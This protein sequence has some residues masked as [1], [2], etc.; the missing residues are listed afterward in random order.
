MTMYLQHFGLREPPFRITPHTE[1]FFSGANRGATLEALL[2]AITAGEGLVK[3]TGEVGSGKTMLC[4]VLME[5]LPETV[6]TLYLAVPSLTRDEMLAAIGDELGI[7][8]TGANTTKLIRLLQ[9]KLIAIH[10]EGRQ[11]VALID[12]AHAM[13][14]ATLEEVRL[15]SNLETG[16]EKLLQ[17]VLFGQPELDEHLALPNMRQLKERITHAFTLAPLPPREIRD[18][19]SFRMRAAG[20]HG[21]DLFDDEVLGIIADASE[22]LTRRINIYSDKALLAAFAA[23]THTVTADHARAAVSDTQI[24]VTRRESPRKMASVAAAG[25]VGGILIGFTAAQFVRAPA[26]APQAVAAS[27]PVKQEQSAPIPAANVAAVAQTVAAVG[28]APPPRAT[29]ALVVP[30]HTFDARLAAGRDLLAG[31]PGLYSV[32]L[33]VA[34]ARQRDYVAGYLAEAAHA[35]SADKLFLVPAGSP[36][37]P[38]LGVLFGAFQDRAD[39]SLAL[40]A[41]PENLKQFRP[42]VRPLDGVREDALRAERR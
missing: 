36:D 40:A 19:V 12:E 29:P 27:A 16:T 41:L 21:P 31:N 32:Q 25:V 34:D 23:G 5:R 38:R 9:E 35:V 7:D 11:V 33:M 4:R 10:A 8:T 28:A 15:L 1:F 39:A 2:Y 42:Y 14:L 13:P 37:A 6:E 30:E 17:L 22:G 18:Y 20:Y 26:G 3:V 24:V